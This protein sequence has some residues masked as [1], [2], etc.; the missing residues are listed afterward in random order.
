LAARDAHIETIKIIAS[1]ARSCDELARCVDFDQ[2]APGGAS[3][4]AEQQPEQQTQP[5]ACQDQHAQ[6]LEELGGREGLARGL[7]PGTTPFDLV[8]HDIF[9]GFHVRRQIPTLMGGGR[10]A[11]IGKLGRAAYKID[12]ETAASGASGL[13]FI[14]DPAD[15][16]SN[17]YD[18]IVMSRGMTD[19]VRIRRHPLRIGPGGSR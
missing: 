17:L 2:L 5:E 1:L 6:F 10:L 3:R 12:N 15:L 18:R 14:C 4:S 9:L 19:R 13:G 7:D 16:P 8:P 11:W